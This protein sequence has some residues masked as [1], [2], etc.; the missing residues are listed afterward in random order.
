M[1]WRRFGEQ[2]SDGRL[3][4][5]VTQEPLLSMPSAQWSEKKQ[6]SGI[7]ELEKR[8]FFPLMILEV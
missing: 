1:K 3:W 8:K 5:P 2:D 4:L 7:R 6:D